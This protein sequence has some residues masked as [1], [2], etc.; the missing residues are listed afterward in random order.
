MGVY[1]GHQPSDDEPKPVS[2]HQIEV[3]SNEL[4]SAIDSLYDL[5]KALVECSRA[6]R[7]LAQVVA[8]DKG[9]AAGL[10]IELPKTDLKEVKL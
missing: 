9:V 4:D 3:L 8:D 10:L 5:R 6:I 2:Q 7:E 1:L